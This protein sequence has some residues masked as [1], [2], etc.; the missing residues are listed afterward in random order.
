MKPDKRNSR[1]EPPSRRDTSPVRILE[2]P[3]DQ[4][5][6][7]VEHVGVWDAERGPLLATG[8]V[9]VPDEGF[10]SLQVLPV[11][12]TRPAGGGGW[13]IESRDALVDL[14]F[15]LDLPDDVVT[16]VNL[17]H[18]VEPA[19]VRHLPHLAPGVQ[20][21][22]LAHAGLTDEALQWIAQLTN[23]TYLQAWGNEFTDA[24]VQQLVGL[25]QLVNLYLEEESLS[26]AAFDF[27]EQLPALER[28]GLQDVELSDAELA[29]LQARLPGVQVGR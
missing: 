14:S 18:R 17:D 29:A 26:L 4:I 16:S 25:Q 27:V 2:F 20:L 7:T 11:A 10:V 8:R 28:L 12:G 6:G 13:S 24:G 1:A 19:S 23:L 22:Y 9:E 21:L 5:V 3:S 15:L